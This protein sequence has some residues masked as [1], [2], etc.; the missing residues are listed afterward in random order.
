[1]EQRGK[2]RKEEQSDVRAESA[3]SEALRCGCGS[4][5]VF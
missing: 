4:K 1:M 5:G 2:E 3:S